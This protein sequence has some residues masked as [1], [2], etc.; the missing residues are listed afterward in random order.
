MDMKRGT[1]IEGVVQIGGK[2]V[3]LPVVTWEV[4]MSRG[5]AKGVVRWGGVYLVQRAGENIAGSLFFLANLESCPGSGWKRPGRCRRD[6]F[7]HNGSDERYDRKAA[8]SRIVKH[9][10]VSNRFPKETIPYY[11]NNWLRKRGATATM[12][13]SRYGR[14]DATD[15]LLVAHFVH[16][17]A[18]G[19]KLEPDRGYRQSRWHPNKIKDGSRRQKFIGEIKAFGE[20][21]RE[22]IRAGLRN[23]A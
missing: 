7:R 23:R 9:R 19:F 12:V 15:H 5:D 11:I 16:P 2:Q 1:E 13:G 3:P 14:H 18:H 10:V 21:Y 22:A 6:D 17:A 8:A 20:Q 4:A